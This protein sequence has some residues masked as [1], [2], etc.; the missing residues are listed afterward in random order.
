MDLE[1]YAVV[2]A[3]MGMVEFAAW[4]L[5][6]WT[7]RQAWHRIANIL[8]PGTGMAL[9][10]IQLSD[11]SSVLRFAVGAAIGV[12]YETLNLIWAFP[13]GR[14]WRLQDERAIALAAGTPW[15]FILAIPPA[16]APVL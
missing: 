3:M 16:L 14:F 7:Y 9:I 11:A 2:L 8:A 4:A 6:S 10:A 1:I 13:R 5:E 15:G 12:A